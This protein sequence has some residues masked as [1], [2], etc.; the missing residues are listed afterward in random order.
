M[1]HDYI[2]QGGKV[3]RETVQSPDWNWV[4]D[5]I[6]DNAGNPFALNYSYDGG[7]SFETYYYVLNYQGDVVALLDSNCNVVA[8]YTYNAWGEI[9]SAT[10]EMAETNPLRYRGYYYDSET[11]FYYVS[12]RYYDPEIGR[13]LNADSVIAGV[14]GHV[15]GHNM[16]AYCFNNP[17]NMVDYTGSWPEWIE[18]TVEAINKAVK[19]VGRAKTEINATMKAPMSAMKIMVAS[20]VAILSGAA[21]PKDVITDLR[22]FEF[23]NN[24]EKKCL[25]S[26]VFSS[27]KGTPVLRHDIPNVTS[28]SIFNTI[29][30][31]MSE[32]SSNG[33]VDT[34][35]HEWGHTVQETMMGR[36]KYLFRIA[37]P[38][39]VGNL[40]GVD[41]YYSQPWERSADYFGEANHSPYK[42][43]SEI[44][45]AIY[46]L[47]P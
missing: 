38:S 3:V 44:I 13:W 21:S 23:Y 32:T 19:K 46:F 34:I 11:G 15:L 43:E 33:G 7:N 39:V 31:N 30:L 47:C 29:I 28:C 10:G 25:E 2:T 45:A 40:I 14:G 5:F 35:R 1:Y 18:K 37:A 9:L 42:D 36:T 17:M 24:N 20:A 26:T 41:D 12:S 8:R 16:F 27:Y 6:Y 22:N 4:L